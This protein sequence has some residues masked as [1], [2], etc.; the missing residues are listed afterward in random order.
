MKQ[1]LSDIKTGQLKNIYLLYGKEDYLKRQ[2]RDKLIKAILPEGDTMNLSSFEG[3]SVNPS[4]LIQI[5]E[6]LPF[7][8]ERRAIV[9]LNSGFFKSG[10][11]ELCKYF[12]HI[13]ETSFFIFVEKEA[14]A[15]T[16]LFKL[17]KN[18][19]CGYAC[20]FEKPDAT[21][22]M[23]WGQSKL[24]AEGLSITRP[25]WQEFMIRTNSTEESNMEFMDQELRKLMSYCYGRE[26][27]E[28][29]DVKAI[30]SGQTE[31]KIFDLMSAISTKNT[32]LTMKLYRDMLETKE[33]PLRILAMIEREFRQILVIK[34]MDADHMDLASIA[35]TVGSPDWAVRRKL[36]LARRMPYDRVEGALKKACDYEERVKSGRLED[37]MAVELFIMQFAK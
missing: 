26:V 18:L 9:V 19:E 29:E 31:G 34:T 23:R 17:V 37:T 2:Y 11:E 13:P 5:S 21:D 24:K 10:Q 14:S 32:D 3:D 4:E 30:C 8:A 28:I 20:D 12:E 16:K 25:A 36:D 22:L 6:T 15:K 7:F 1:I 35:S 27:I 33:A